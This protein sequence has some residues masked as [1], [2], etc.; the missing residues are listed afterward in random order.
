MQRKMENVH[1]NIAAVCSVSLFLVF[2]LTE[3]AEQAINGMCVYNTRQN[4]NILY[5]N[6]ANYFHIQQIL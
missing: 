3:A 1:C 2:M 4:D 6:Y 5:F